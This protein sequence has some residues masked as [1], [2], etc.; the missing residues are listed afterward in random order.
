[1][2][3]FQGERGHRTRATSSGKLWS[4]L[5]AVDSYLGVHPAALRFYTVAYFTPSRPRRLGNVYVKR[6][7]RPDTAVSVLHVIL[8][9][10][11]ETLF[12]ACN[13]AV[14]FQTWR[15]FYIVRHEN[16]P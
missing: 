16:T 15:A 3:V 10:A 5:H 11:I 12:T 14:R 8:T 13:M 4:T 2:H 6:R 9:P 1:M 7:A